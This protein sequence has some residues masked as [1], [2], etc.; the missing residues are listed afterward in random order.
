MTVAVTADRAGA[1]TDQEA[2]EQAG[3]RHQGDRAACRIGPDLREI[4]LVKVEAN[5]ADPRGD[6]PVCRYFPRQDRGRARRSSLV[7]ELTGRFTDK[8]QEFIALLDTYGV[9]K[10]FV[11]TGIT[12]LERGS[13]QIDQYT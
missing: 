5:A 12:A 3:G 13:K 10:E 8:V 4:A 7:I 1:G 6:H 11:R 9:I 2:G